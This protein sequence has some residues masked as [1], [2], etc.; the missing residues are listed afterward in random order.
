MCAHDDEELTEQPRHHLEVWEPVLAGNISLG[1]VV[2]G[3]GIVV[4]SERAAFGARPG[5]VVL[6]PPLDGVGQV[7]VRN[8]DVVASPCAHRI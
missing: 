5:F 3:N 6:G 7:N 2:R 8:H 4:V 1:A